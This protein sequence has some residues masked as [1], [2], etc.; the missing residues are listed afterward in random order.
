MSPSPRI[1]SSRLFEFI[2]SQPLPLTWGITLP[3][4]TR[5]CSTVNYFLQRWKQSPRS[6]HQLIPAP[7]ANLQMLECPASQLPLTDLPWGTFPTFAQLTSCLAR[8]PSLWHSSRPYAPALPTTL[9]PRVTSPGA[10]KPPHVTTAPSQGFQ[11]FRH[12]FLATSL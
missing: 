5:L 2:G 10:S 7:P 8:A 4:F 12:C 3:C 11:T 1:P 6:Q 9:S